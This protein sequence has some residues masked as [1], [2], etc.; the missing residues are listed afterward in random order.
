[1][2][3]KSSSEKVTDLCDNSQC[4]IIIDEVS[5]RVEIIFSGKLSAIPSIKNAKEIKYH[6]GRPYLINNKNTMDHLAA[7][8]ILFKRK[9]DSL[10]ISKLTFGESKVFVL[11][12]CAKRSQKFDPINT[13]ET[14]QDWLEPSH[15]TSGSKAGNT[16]GWGVGVIE[17]D[18]QVTSLAMH[19]K[20]AGG[21]ESST[22]IIIVPLNS[23]IKNLTELVKCL[24]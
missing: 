6:N 2:R 20:D 17:N 8:D 13:C 21:D 24:I 1:M 23:I 16:R 12:L 19:Q 10:N 3:R 22:R 4:D 18:S 9:L 14:V 7:M 15:K 5:K 11:L